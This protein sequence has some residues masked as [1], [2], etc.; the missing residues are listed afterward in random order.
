MKNFV[1]INFEYYKKNQASGEISH[2]MRSFAKNKNA[3][4]HLSSENF[5]S[6]FDL[7]KRYNESLEFAEINTKQKTGKKSQVQN[8][9]LDG[10]L[11][12]S[13]EKMEIIKKNPNWKEEFSKEIEKYMLDIQQRTGFMPV[14]WK[15]HL[16]EGYNNSEDGTNINHHAHLLFLNHNVD[17]GTSPLRNFKRGDSVWSELQDLAGKRFENL[18]FRRGVS[19]EQ[20]HRNHLS[21]NEYI[22]KLQEEAEAS[23]NELRRGIETCEKAL[24]EAKMALIKGRAGVRAVSESGVSSRAFITDYKALQKQIQKCSFVYEK[25]YNNGGF[26]YRATK[27]LKK[28][29][30]KAHDFLASTA[31]KLLDLFKQDIP[32]LKPEIID[33]IEYSTTVIDKLI[34]EQKKAL[35]EIQGSSRNSKNKFRI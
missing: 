3:I 35:E 22:A 24:T 5:G 17:N 11:V 28:T 21:K 27:A 9:L 18:G 25:S 20:T 10:V 13:P 19:K 6:D 32:V 7:L 26:F 15:F 33:E 2:V 16:D 4:P 14:G 34:A 29:M 12:F 31:T 8:T 1:A 30:P 23:Q